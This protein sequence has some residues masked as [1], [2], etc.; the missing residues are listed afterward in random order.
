MAVRNRKYSRA[1][2][3]RQFLKKL[4]VAGAAGSGLFAAGSPFLPALAAEPKAAPGKPGPF[5]LTVPPSESRIS[6]KHVNG[7]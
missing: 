5:F 1:I 4:G 7:R 3:R 2:S 6:W